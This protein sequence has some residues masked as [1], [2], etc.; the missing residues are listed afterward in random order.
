MDE[1]GRK[2]L[3]Q[4]CG[5]WERTSAAGRHYLVGRMGGVKVLVLENG[6]R[7]SDSEPCHYLCLGEAPP[8]ASMDR[9]A[10]ERKAKP[11]E[12]APP[13]AEWSA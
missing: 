13:E 6:K 5:L 7:Q 4:A 2:P 3:L 9:P 1:N 10:A 12:A 8:R 11:S